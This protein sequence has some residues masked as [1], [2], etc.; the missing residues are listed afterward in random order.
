MKPSQPKA[1][2][3]AGINEQY[4]L[5]VTVC[6]GKSYPSAEVVT[7]QFIQ[8]AGEY[9]KTIG[10]LAVYRSPIGSYKTSRTPKITTQKIQYLSLD[11]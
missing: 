6:P 1:R 3:N 5:G 10:H 8:R 4:Y 7:I 9:W 11:N 2:F